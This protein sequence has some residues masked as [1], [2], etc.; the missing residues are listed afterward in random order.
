M[1]ITEVL[2][3]VRAGDRQAY[4]TVVTRYQNGMFAFLGRMGLTQ[5][6]AEEVAQETFLRAWTHLGEFDPR[7]GAF[8]TWI[9]TI[10][11]RLA[12][13]E[14]ARA[15]NQ[16]EVTLTVE[17]GSACPAPQPPDTLARA[18]ER[19]RLHAAIGQLPPGDRCVLAL[20]Y[21]DELT[22]ADVARIEGCAVGA[23]KTRLHRA[24]RRLAELLE[25]DD[26]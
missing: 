2:R 3:R 4:A 24:R 10:A 14:I 13:N 17:P 5:A 22:L 15:A 20:F 16:Q 6:R 25:S 26:A 9:Y 23:A 19:Q 21:I 1:N 11:R 8:S 7:R 12:L 18:E